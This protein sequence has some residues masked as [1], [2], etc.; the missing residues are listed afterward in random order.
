MTFVKSVNLEKIAKI[1]SDQMCP[2]FQRGEMKGMDRE[3]NRER[4]IECT[5]NVNICVCVRV[6]AC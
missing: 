4:E 6:C 5:C 3:R 1:P 2:L